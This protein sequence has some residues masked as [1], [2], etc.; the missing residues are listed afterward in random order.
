MALLMTLH[1]RLLLALSFVLIGINIFTNISQSI[2]SK[3]NA[4]SFPLHRLAEPFK[5]LKP[6]FTHQVAAG[7]LTDKN[8]DDVPVIARYELAQFTLAPTVL[9]LNDSKHPFVLIDASDPTNAMRLLKD[10]QLTPLK[11][12]NNGLILSVNKNFISAP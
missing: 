5:A 2:A 12:D 7:Y 8:I 11:I 9:L 3:N 6:V 4:Q 10:N 1:N